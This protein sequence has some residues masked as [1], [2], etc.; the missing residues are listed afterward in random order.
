MK[1]LNLYIFTRVRHMNIK[2]VE[3]F[4]RLLT[5]RG[6]DLELREY[7]YQTIVSLVDDLM[8]L[9]SVLDLEGFYYSYSIPQ[10]GEEFDLLKLSEEK[11]ISIELKSQHVSEKAIFKQLCNKKHYLSHLPGA[12]YYY[13]YVKGDKFLY[14]LAADGSLTRCAIELLAESLKN[15]NG[16]FTGNLDDRFRVAQFLVSPVNSPDKF[17]HGNYF[18]TPQQ[19]L[20]ESKITGQAEERLGIDPLL[21]SVHGTPGTGKTLLLYHLA[22][23]FSSEKRVCIV[24]CAPNT[25]QHITLQ[26]M[27]KDV[28]IVIPKHLPYLNLSLF[29]VFVIDETQR[30]YTSQL[31]EVISHVRENKKMCIMGIDPQQVMS[32]KERNRN[33]DEHLS[34][35][36][37]IQDFKLSKKIRTNKEIAGFIEVMLNLAKAKPG[38]KYP[39]VSLVFAN[40]YDEGRSIISHYEEQGYT[41]ISY[42]TSL[43][44]SD[45]IDYI[46]S[47][48]NTHKVIGQ[49]FDNVL[50]MLDDHFLYDI[51]GRLQAK[52]HPNPDYLFPKLFYQG[53]T[54]VRE[55]LMVLVIDNPELF[56]R[57]AD[58]IGRPKEEAQDDVE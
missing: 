3:K 57:I 25:Q 33:I 29:D 5:D 8:P 39:N 18:L 50:I 38:V 46:S 16:F 43:H 51:S 27:W 45:K 28:R 48:H 19:E 23:K 2:S 30:I 36:S 37:D 11:V 17:L 42:T 55:K 54:R 49:E 22:K 14:G 20:I 58:A 40:S 31:D 21:F 6:E 34:R 56:I 13:T 7:E 10:L 47:I 44:S 41:Y 15:H 4:A 12:H 24:H 1:P 9:V 52:N 32:K 26:G 53:I 35:I